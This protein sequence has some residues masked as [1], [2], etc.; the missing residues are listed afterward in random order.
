[1]CNFNIF[2]S[3]NFYT[4]SIIYLSQ[5]SANLFFKGPD[6]KYFRLDRPGSMLEYISI[7]NSTHRVIIRFKKI[8]FIR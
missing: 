3:K 2:R 1:M 5:V 7:C 4:H 6:R 8:H